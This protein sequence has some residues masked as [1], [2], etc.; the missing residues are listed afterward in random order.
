MSFDGTQVTP[1]PRFDGLEHIVAAPH[2]L[3]AIDP[4]SQPPGLVAFDDR[5]VERGRLALPMSWTRGHEPRLRCARVRC[6]MRWGDAHGENTMVIENDRDGRPVLGHPVR[7]VELP[8]PYR[9]WDLSADGRWIA[10]PVKL[11]PR[12]LLIYD[13]ERGT[14]RYIE[15][16][17]CANVDWVTFMPNGGLAFSTL[18]L[19]A[20]QAEPYTVVT[21]DPD[22]REQVVW[23][24]DQYVSRLL[25]LDDHKILVST[26]SYDS[27][28]GLLEP[29]P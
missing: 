5:G 8:V 19:G 24:G 15:C 23:R 21:R 16:Q 6:V 25:P 12:T 2:G 17:R 4:H 10:G 3:L 18:T 27:K 9:P 1:L 7:A 28:L 26:I 13:V 14:V 11:S 20:V 29:A 22:G